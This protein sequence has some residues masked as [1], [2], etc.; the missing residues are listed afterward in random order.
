[1]TPHAVITVVTPDRWLNDPVFQINRISSITC[2]NLLRKRTRFGNRC[3]IFRQSPNKRLMPASVAG[4]ATRGPGGRHVS[5]NSSTCCDDVFRCRLRSILLR[6]QL[7]QLA[8]LHLTRSGVL[9]HWRHLLQRWQHVLL[10]PTLLP[11]GTASLLGAA[12]LPTGSALL[13]GAALL[14]TCA[15]LL[16]EPSLAWQ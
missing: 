9:Q 12:L 11:G 6:R 1:M 5:T 13:L 10:G 3:L 4:A 8:G 7:L 14:P 2:F 15:A 16:R